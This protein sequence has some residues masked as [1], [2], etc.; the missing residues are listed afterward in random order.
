M[1]KI[2]APASDEL[3]TGWDRQIPRYLATRAL[4]PPERERYKFERPFTTCGD[5]D[6]WQ[7]L[8]QP[9]AAGQKIETTSWPHD[10]FLPLNETAK[11]IL[12][13]FKLQ[14]KSRLTQSPWRDGRMYLDN[15]MTGGVITPAMMVTPKLPRVAGVGG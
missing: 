11:Q 7:Y 6:T 4:K 2:H 3:P 15:G 14:M 5:P 1:A 8:T 13:F 10:S 9:I 12:A